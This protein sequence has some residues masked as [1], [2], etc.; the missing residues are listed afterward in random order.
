[1]KRSPSPREV[2][3][4]STRELT[5]A[6]ASGRLAEP[7]L[8][9]WA[10][11][12]RSTDFVQRQ[13]LRDLYDREVGKLPDFV[14]AA[15]QWI[16]RSW[17][18]PDAQD[19]Y[20]R[21]L[22]RRR[23]KSG[24]LSIGDIETFVSGARPIIEVKSRDSIDRLYDLRR[25]QNPKSMHD[26]L[27]FS[28][29][30][31][32]TDV[33]E[34]IGLLNDLDDSALIQ[35]S[36]SLLAALVGMLFAAKEMGLVDGDADISLWQV[37]RAYF[38]PPDQHP[39]GGG[40]PDRH[41]RGFAPSSKLIHHALSRLSHRQPDFVQGVM[42][43]IKAQEFGLCQRLWAALA[44]DTKLVSGNEVAAFLS[45]LSHRDFWSAGSY[46]EYAELRAVR[47]N[48]APSHSRT[49]LEKRLRAG[50]PVSTMSRRLSTEQRASAK[51]HNAVAELSRIRSAGGELSKSTL[52][53]L[54]NT[55][56][57][58]SVQLEKA[59]DGFN[60]GVIAT[61]GR[62]SS[63]AKF[64]PPRTDRLLPALQKAIGDDI[65][66]DDGQSAADY[67]TNHASELIA[68]L[69][70]DTKR[71]SRYAKI[72]D[73][74]GHRIRPSGKEVSADEQELARAMARLI[75]SLSFDTIKLA[76]NGLSEW[77]SSWSKH[78][79]LKE[80]L[81]PTWLHV[82]D[83]AVE[84]TNA[85]APSDD[86][87]LRALNTP[88]GKMVSAFLDVCP[89]VNGEVDPFFNTVLG[90]MRDRLLRANGSAKEDV[91]YRLL[92]EL[93][94]FYQASPDWTL[95]ELVEPLSRSVSPSDWLSFS[96]SPSLP[97]PQVI[98][99]LAASIELAVADRESS[100][101]IRASIMRIAIL[102]VVQQKA[103]DLDPAFSDASLQQM[104]RL[105]GDSARIAAVRAL[106][107][108][109]EGE[110]INAASELF[111]KVVEP[112]FLDAWPKETAL[113]SKNLSKAL[114]R[115]PAA[116]LGRYEEAVA[117]VISYVSSFDCWSLWDFG[118]HES[119]EDETKK[120][121]KLR[122]EGDALA[123]LSLLDKSVSGED[124]AVIPH[125]IEQ[126]LQAIAAK[127][128]RAEKDVRY[129]RLLTLARR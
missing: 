83:A 33:S 17:D 63:S 15:W 129:Q 34:A 2:S 91:M 53:W 4:R 77:L 98:R 10:V 1:M 66:S 37:R 116:Y 123:F 102:H 32:D 103:D 16:I 94:Y 36:L 59:T 125:D 90:E 56:V 8:L 117:L 107:D 75:L 58:Q 71:P 19:S 12:L 79:R 61:W 92:S 100:D 57:P 119:A 110:Q 14:S 85:E 46:P 11:A 114:V 48:D 18:N 80:D 13:V 72:V 5:W 45:S 31:A 113:V 30:S 52:R 24:H 105:G 120:L 43:A 38:V 7:E 93:T 124:G 88:T 42:G 62:S 112:F 118:L 29:T 101:E 99:P 111:D 126:A 127:S 76:A 70:A 3:D 22:F 64:S 28:I 81:A 67:V 25:D 20:E 6:F 87:E 44:R 23:A 54:S 50:Q 35:I 96:H 27:H 109:G 108:V 40:E 104:L 97:P 115:L 21:L 95:R 47:W 69:S 82:W 86:I 128:K 26:L 41:S 68:L 65:W 49:E 89:T 55:N 121:G 51:L 74:L 84:S 60:R 122:S 73:L 9:E 106:A 39:P 78:L